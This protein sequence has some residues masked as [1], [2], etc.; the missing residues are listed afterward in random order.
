MFCA[1]TYINS[2][3]SFPWNVQRNSFSKHYLELVVDTADSGSMKGQ[4]FAV[5]Y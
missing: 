4:C 1:C 5:N 2:G 3:C